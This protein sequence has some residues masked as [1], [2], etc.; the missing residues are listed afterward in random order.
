MQGHRQGMFS[1]HN[2]LRSLLPLLKSMKSYFVTHCKFEHIDCIKFWRRGNFCQLL[3]V[4]NHS[5]TM[6]VDEIFVGAAEN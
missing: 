5:L 1:V 3:D 6:S 4:T 2:K